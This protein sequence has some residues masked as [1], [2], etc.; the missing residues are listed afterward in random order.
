[1]SS[2]IA[3]FTDFGHLMAGIFTELLCPSL[4]INLAQLVSPSV[5]L[6]DE[7]V[8]CFCGHKSWSCLGI[9]TCQS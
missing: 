6:Q 4:I 1:M 8:E 3:W 5:A 7:L 9:G 2:D